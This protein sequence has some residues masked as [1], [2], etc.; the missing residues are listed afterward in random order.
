MI[1]VVVEVSSA[2]ISAG[3]TAAPGTQQRRE[4]SSA[5]NTAAPGTQQRREHSSAARFPLFDD[6][7]NRTWNL[8]AGSEAIVRRAL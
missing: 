2:T 3:N 7:L 6:V 8:E 5:G 1:A 4:H